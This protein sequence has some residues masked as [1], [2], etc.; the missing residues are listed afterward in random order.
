MK[1]VSGIAALIAAFG[2]VSANAT[3]IYLD[4]GAS[5]PGAATAFSSNV[6]A[7][8]A[9]WMSGDNNAARVGDAQ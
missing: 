4:A 9:A 2:C 8:L 1:V 6:A 3:F 7:G 5:R